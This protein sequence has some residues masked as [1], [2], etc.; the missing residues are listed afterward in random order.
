MEE[1]PPL[2]RAGVDIACQHFEDLF[3]LLEFAGG[4]DD[5]LKGSRQP[6]E[7]PDHQGI[8]GAHVVERGFEFRAVT[9]R[10]GRF[11]DIEPLAPG[12]FQGVDL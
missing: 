11:L 8:A 4:L 7:P 9:M 12:L 5:L 2:G 6:G 1:Q 10:A 3:L